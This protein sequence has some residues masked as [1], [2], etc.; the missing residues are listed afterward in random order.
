MTTLASV[1]AMSIA[2]S[3]MR[4]SAS[5]SRADARRI[6]DTSASLEAPFTMSITA[7]RPVSAT[8]SSSAMTG[9]RS[10]T[11]QSS[12]AATA[13]E[14]IPRWAMMDAHSTQRFRNGASEPSTSTT[15]PRCALAATRNAL[16]T[17]GRPNA[18]CLACASRSMAASTSFSASSGGVPVRSPLPTRDD[19]VGEPDASS[20]RRADVGSG[21]FVFVGDTI[22]DRASSSSICS[23]LSPAER[24]PASTT[25][26]FGVVASEPR[27]RNP[28]LFVPVRELGSR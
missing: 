24:P 25:L 20:D 11:L 1:A 8:A 16:T 10:R 7:G 13:L 3:C 9:V 23:A 2:R 4:S 14:S 18:A 12:A 17:P 21:G 28:A 19:L 26:D 15:S 22:D 6:R 27:S 5:S